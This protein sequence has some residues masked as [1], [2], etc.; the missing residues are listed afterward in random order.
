MRSA[1]PARSAARGAWVRPFVLLVVAVAG[2][3][4]LL[5]AG[6]RWVAWAAL[7]AALATI[8]HRVTTAEMVTR[9]REQVATQRGLARYHQAVATNYAA[10]YQRECERRERRGERE[11]ERERDR[12]PWEA[13]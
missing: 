12:R 4:A 9:L 10:L 8:A 7:G 3:V 2:W 13:A 5:A 6:P 11:R 1:D